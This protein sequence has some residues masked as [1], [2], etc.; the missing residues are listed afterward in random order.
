[1]NLMDSR[2]G[3]VPN[4]YGSQEGFLEEVDFLLGSIWEDTPGQRVQLL[5]TASRGH[6]GFFHVIVF[7]ISSF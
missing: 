1:M 5:S 6:D 4:S 7:I 2:R 3:R